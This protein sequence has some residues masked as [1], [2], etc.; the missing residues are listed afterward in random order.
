MQR[1]AKR[2]LPLFLAIFLLLTTFAGTLAA[3]SG[4]IKITSKDAYL[5]A[6]IDL[7]NCPIAQR[8]QYRIYDARGD[9]AATVTA[10]ADG[11]V[12]ASNLDV[13]SY[14]VEQISAAP[15]YSIVTGTFT[16]AVTSS[17]TTSN[18]A[19]LDFACVP[20]AV[21]IQ[22][23]DASDKSPMAGIKFQ[24]QASGDSTPL[25]FA[26][27]GD[28]NYILANG[29]YAALESSDTSDTLE[30]DAQGR[31]TMLYLPTGENYMLSEEDVTGLGFRTADS[32]TFTVYEDNSIAYPVQIGVENWP[33]YLSVTKKDS[34]TNEPIGNSKVQVLDAND[35]PLHF[36]PAKDGSYRVTEEGVTEIPS[37]SDGS[38]LISHMLLVHTKSWMCRTQGT[39]I[40]PTPLSP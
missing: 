14:E 34:E 9:V 40:P 4:A 36:T 33:L 32:Q 7:T 23:L 8:P 13:G 16:V 21:S 6:T 27:R 35:Q 24:V 15:G 5:D 29:M 11:T 19:T 1:I 30:T 39:A 20:T 3:G 18:P 10:G 31:I 22:K 37:G 25:S 17:H 26:K 38:V 2:F 12:T 28:G